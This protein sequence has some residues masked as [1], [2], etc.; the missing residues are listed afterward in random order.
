MLIRP[1]RADD[2][3]ALAPLFAD[4]EHAQPPEFIA[5]RLSAWSA[6]PYAEVLVAELEGALAGVV[7]VAAT[8][9][10]A[11]PGRFARLVGLAVG[12]GFRRR[13]VGAALVRATEELARSWHC[14]RLELT[15]SRW[16]DE[17]PA[18][19]VA[20]GYRDQSDRQARYLRA[21]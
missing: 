9:H 17:A 12:S 21:L 13:G 14:D 16:R 1:A 11:R 5:E 2:A 3:S 8:P 6:T 19:Y 18:F 7:A 4:W 15:S 10:L 20:L